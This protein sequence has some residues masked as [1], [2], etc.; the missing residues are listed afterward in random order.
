M[1]R[2]DPEGTDVEGDAKNPEEPAR[3][4]RRGPIRHGCKEMWV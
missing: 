1:L 4:G 2:Y 3:S